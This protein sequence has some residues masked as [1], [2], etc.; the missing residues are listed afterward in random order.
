MVSADETNG[1]NLL[2]VDDDAELCAMMR[3]FFEQS[4][5]I[6]DCVLN[7]TDGLKYAIAKDYDLVILDVMLPG[8]NGFLLLSQLRRRR[9]VPVIMLTAKTAPRDR[10]QGLESG[11]DDY[12]PKPFDPDE[13]LARV[14]AVL[15]RTGKVNPDWQRNLASGDLRI[16]GQTRQVWVRSEP[17][18][19]TAVEFDIL[20]Q[21]V[22][23]AGRV[24]TREE[25]TTAIL[26]RS[27]TPYDRSLDVHISHLRRKLEAVGRQIQTIRGVGYLFTSNRRQIT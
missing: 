18:D 19:L 7:G 3:E 13:L 10:I 9:E 12:L 25:L 5:H 2:L 1:L 6:L 23:S 16:S 20:Y 26:E 24:V 11:A 14:R 17:V 8:L 22:S 4:G 21:L 27:P 15:R